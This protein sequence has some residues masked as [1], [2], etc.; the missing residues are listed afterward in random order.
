MILLKEILPALEPKYKAQLLSAFSAHELLTAYIRAT[1]AAD[2]R[3]E[4]IDA[5]EAARDMLYSVDE[6]AEREIKRY[7]A[8]LSDDDYENELER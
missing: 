7:L 6:A 2:I 3:S 8:D 5:G 4:G 1:V